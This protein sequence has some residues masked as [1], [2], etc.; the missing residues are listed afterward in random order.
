MGP[1]PPGATYHPDTFVK[2]LKCFQEQKDQF[3]WFMVVDDDTYLF[4]ERLLSWLDLIDSR[5]SL[6][7][8]D[9]INWPPLYLDWPGVYQACMK[10]LPPLNYDYSLW[11]GG[12]PGLVF[13]GACVDAVLEL[14]SELTEID[15]PALAAINHDVWL[16]RI[17]EVQGRSRIARLH[18]PGFHQFGDRALLQAENVNPRSLISV[19]LNHSVE[20]MQKFHD[21][22]AT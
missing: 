15:S 3:Q 14:I 13:S 2:I 5:K 8:G 7:I 21:L 19:H 16:H 17:I 22:A 4:V 11:P 1:Y 9:F 10:K 20:L 12:G 6:L 18:C